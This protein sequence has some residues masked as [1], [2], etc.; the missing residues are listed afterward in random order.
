MG[1]NICKWCDWHGLSFQNIETAHTAQCQKDKQP[2][3]RWAVDLNRHFSKKD[4]QIAN[5]H[6]IRCSASLIIR[7]MQI[8]IT[9]RYHLTSVRMAII[10]KS[11]NNKWWRGC[12]ENEPHYIVLENVKWYAIMQNHVGIPLK[13][14]YAITIWTRS[15]TPGYKFREY[16]NSKRCM[17]PDVHC[18]TIYSN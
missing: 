14:K 3:Q 4:M 11:A 13:T 15:P 12:G 10:K 18:C 5:R 8:K 2:N 16:Y 9:M 7:E 1:K 6:M 17:N